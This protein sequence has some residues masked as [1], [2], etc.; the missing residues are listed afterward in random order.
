MQRLLCKRAPLF[1]L[2]AGALC[3]LAPA[4]DAQQG[5]GSIVGHIT[6][7]S[8]AV[9]PGAT[10]TITNQSTLQNSVL[11]TDGEGK[12]KSPPL[13]TGT[14]TI[15][16]EKTGF[17]PEAQKNYDVSDDQNGVVDF[18][19]NPGNNT[20]QVDVQATAST[21]NTFNAS[22]GSVIDNATAE[23]LP[24]N[25]NNALALSQLDPN[26]ISAVGPV[27]EGFNDRGTGVSNI[28]V[29]GG[30]AGA[31][32]N[33]FD[34]A[35]NL[36]T[37]RGEILINS[38]V[39]GIA[40]ARTMYGVVSAQYGL[41]SGGVI[42][43]TS[44]SG[45]NQLHGQIYGY[46]RNAALDAKGYFALPGTTPI[47]NY[48][49]YGAAL[50]G[51]IL[52][53]RMFFFA[54]YEA[55]SN[56]QTTPIQQTLPTAA[57]RTG[58][59][60]ASGSVI[61][62]P[63]TEAAC[64]AN[65]T[66]GTCRYQYGYGPGMTPGAFGNPIQTG[67]VNVIPSSE[68]NQAAYAFQNQF[69][70]SPNVA[71]ALTDNYVSP[72]PLVSAQHVSIG[73]I[74]W[75]VASHL[76]AFVRYAYYDNIT[77]NYGGYGY[78]TATASTRNDLLR[79]QQVDIGFTQILSG[80]LINDIR[81]ATGRSYF[82]YLAGSY[83]QNQPQNLGISNLPANTLPY[84][85][86]QN[87]NVTDS[88]NQGLRT[89]TIPEIND[90][91]IWLLGKHDLHIGVG[92]RFYQAYNNA[93]FYPSGEFSFNTTQT[94][95]IIQSETPTQAG[96]NCVL[97]GTQTTCSICYENGAVNYNCIGTGNAYATFLLGQAASITSNVSGDSVPESYSVN[98]FIQDDWRA[99]KTLTLNIG[100]RYD[101]QAVPWD[102]AN[103]YSTLR[104]NQPNPTN[105]LLGTEVYAGPKDRNFANENYNN[106][107]PRVGFAWLVSSKHQT[108]IR[109]GYAAYFAAAFN[110]IY[111]NTNDGFGTLSTS[112]QANSQYGYVGLLSQGFPSPPE[113]LAGSSDGPN[114]L[115]GETAS[116]QPAYA[117]T[118]KSQQFVLAIDHQF[119]KNTVI[120]ISGLYNHGTN[121]PMTSIN[122][123]ALNPY[124]YSLGYAKLEAQTNNPYY[125]ILHAWNSTPSFT[126]KSIQE[127]KAL[128]PYPYFQ[129]V[130]EYYPHIGSFSGRS[131][132]V[133]FRRPIS[134]N[135][136]GQLGY[137][138]AKLL[139]DPLQSSISSSPTPSGVL[140][141]NYAAHS[142][143]GF[144]SSDV[145]HRIS[146]NMTYTFPFG[147]GQRFLA[148]L[149][150]GHDLWV[151]GWTMAGTVIGETG[152]PLQ[153]TGGN[154]A[155]ATRPDFVPGQPLKLAHP[156][157]KEWFNTA[158]FTIAPY[159]T[160]GNV[161]RTLGAVRSPGSL[162]LNLNLGKITK[163]G[164]YTAEFRVDAF[165]ALNKTNFGTP[166]TGY[167]TLT[168]TIGAGATPFGAITTATQART[169]QL[170]GRFRF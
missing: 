126:S 65:S 152:R 107:G 21:L 85:S 69:I 95:A 149:S 111:Q 138:F 139:D 77:N 98:G 19:I 8:G 17:R 22:L 102:K 124:Y 6:D 67:P 155:G 99:T 40:E 144:D 133:I 68:F 84:I 55:Y 125:N 39:T 166:N 41:T 47:L 31:N 58:D 89:S 91:V 94:A 93:N 114:L 110:G 45:T 4:A 151:S 71:G 142:E 11:I 169:L 167:V 16:V 165:N 159:F 30:L 80:T 106:F 64:T 81:I 101:Y 26:V 147:K 61:Y 164:R 20:E 74:D 48:K 34:G 143:W 62:D 12:Y 78:L 59:F 23:A 57:E 9:V 158:A 120:D 116:V 1:F 119:A 72:V 73:R 128:T 42:T 24:L 51:P 170:T 145:T 131:L 29:A 163:V 70:P 168:S 76:T 103:G 127:L 100:L 52:H 90:T 160:F 13:D 122:L 117:P 154:N 108:V 56:Q 27:N 113:P 161:P 130:Y 49:Q 35:Y 14:Y 36:Q 112:Y 135:I 141:N 137:A 136:Q 46:F 2:I 28:R 53:N 157:A 60:S 63:S 18:K 132:S 44:K 82:P 25:G 50:G 150:T 66:N 88:T 96:P 146:G 123:N 7:P 37:S 79:N 38:T 105:G 148:N 87:Y 140:Q 33:L 3:L 43:Q 92:Y 5:T 118:S 15:E 115:L 54:N 75:Q 134:T 153:I 83:G 104:L 10:V 86:I 97:T 129:N 121:F 32:A 162:S 156:T 109:G